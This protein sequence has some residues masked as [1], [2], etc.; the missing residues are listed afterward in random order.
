MIDS[1][2]RLI[3]I[4]HARKNRIP[5]SDDGRLINPSTVYRWIRQGLEG[6]DGE[7]IRLEVTYRGQTPYTSAEAIDRFFAAVTMARLARMERTQQRCVD[8]S[9]SDLEE[10]GLSQP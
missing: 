9:A 1:T 5:P 6:L 3:S 10:A 7:R 8:P 4:S 2:E